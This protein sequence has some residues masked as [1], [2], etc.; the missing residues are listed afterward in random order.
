[1]AKSKGVGDVIAKAT[2][3]IGIEPCE[4][5]LKRKELLNKLF[6]FKRVSKITNNH[7]KKLA[8]LDSLKD[9]ELI[10]LYND[11][12]NTQLESLPANVKNAVINDLKKIIE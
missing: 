11:I 4:G 5:C 9:S 6:P 12:F 7:K 1:M 8:E 2:K 10:E 3:A